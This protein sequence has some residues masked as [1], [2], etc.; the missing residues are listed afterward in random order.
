MK[1]FKKCKAAR[2]AY[3]ASVPF[4]KLM[5]LDMLLMHGT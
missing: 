3:G 5:K 2:H 1:S 4:G